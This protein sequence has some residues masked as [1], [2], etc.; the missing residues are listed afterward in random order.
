MFYS[1]HITPRLGCYVDGN[2]KSK[3]ESSIQLLTNKQTPWPE[4][5]NELYRPSDH[6]LSANLMPTFAER[7]CCVVSV[8]DPYGRILG[9]LD[10]SRY[11]FFQVAPQLYL[12]G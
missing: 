9:F 4:S 6:R 7:V 8:T 12:R 1:L 11:F 3:T 10:R 5:A 2:Y